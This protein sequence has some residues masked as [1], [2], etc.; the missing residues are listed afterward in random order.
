MAKPTETDYICMIITL[1]EAYEQTGAGQAVKQG[2]P[3]TFKTKCFLALFVLLQIKQQVAFKAQRRWLEAH[4][5]I[6]QMFNWPR[7]PHR[8]TFS[9][10]YKQLYRTLQQFIPFV[11]QY[12]WQL[13]ADFNL[14]H[15]VEDKSL[16]RAQGP[17]WHQK[18]RLAGI[19]PERL[20]HLDQDATWSKS[21]YQGW[22]YGYGLHLTCNESGLPVLLQVETANVHEGDV[23]DQKAPAIFNLQPDTVAA[24]NGY[25]KAMRLRRWPLSGVVLLTPA[26]SWTDSRYARAY[27]RF[28]KRPENQKR[29]HRRR[30]SVEPAF[31]LVTRLLQRQHDRKHLPVQSLVNVRTCLSLAVFSL[32]L[33]M[34]VNSIWDLPHRCISH[35]IAA[36]A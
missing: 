18:Q 3:Y 27:H 33:A 2:R 31:D 35:L 4:P 1:F 14:K 10:R 8:T 34:I 23:I 22:V 6:Q 16:F 25:T 20:R 24:D 5:R 26:A 7:V 17:V 28:I 21:G 11:A 12:A 19:I 13:G 9:R 15:L 32:Q 29:L 30:T 36:C